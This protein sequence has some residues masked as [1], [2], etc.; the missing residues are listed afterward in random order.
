MC[1]SRRQRWGLLVVLRD[2]NEF[3]GFMQRVLYTRWVFLK[4]LPHVIVAGTRFD[5]EQPSFLPKDAQVLCSSS[6]SLWAKLALV[7]RLSLQTLQR[8][9]AVV[10]LHSCTFT[11]LLVPVALTAKL[12]GCRVIYNMHDVVPETGRRYRKGK[13]PVTL[14]NLIAWGAVLVEWL[15]V[16]LADLVVFPGMSYLNTVAGRYPNQ[17]GKMEIVSNIPWILGDQSGANSQHSNL[18]ELYGLPDDA[19]LIVFAGEVSRNVQGVELIIQ[20]QALLCNE[21]LPVYT[22]IIGKGVNQDERVYFEKL[23]A[24]LNIGDRVFFLGQLPRWEVMAILPQCDLTILVAFDGPTHKIFEYLMSGLVPIMWQDMAHHI[25]VIGDGAVYFDDLNS[26]S[27]AEAVRLVLRN[28][29]QYKR[30][31]RERAERTTLDPVTAHAPFFEAL[32]RWLA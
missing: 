28:L 22:F 29:G 17:R 32:D 7:M 26:S 27:V 8:C 30:E 18:R 2:L 15:L 13:H 11:L 4:Y 9:Y 6:S 23:V 24:H 20:T 31:A 1:P 12:G 10:S 3:K 14:I 25:K 5:P 21:L 19:C 16:S